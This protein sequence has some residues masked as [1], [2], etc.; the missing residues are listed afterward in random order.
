MRNRREGTHPATLAAAA[1][2][3]KL[4]LPEFCV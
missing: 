4:T 3:A 2:R 1:E